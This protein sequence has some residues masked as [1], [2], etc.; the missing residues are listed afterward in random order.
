[1][2]IDFMGDKGG[3]R[4]NYGKDF[5]LYSA[6]NG[7]LQSIKPDYNI[8]DMYEIEDLRFVEAVRKGLK[9]RSYIDEVLESARLLDA[10]YESA[11]KQKEITVNR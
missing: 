1:M 7:M 10:I 3:I 5:T 9:T 4:L 2:F 6:E 11:E 8:P